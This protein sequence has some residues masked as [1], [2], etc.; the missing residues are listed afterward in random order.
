M[1]YETYPILIARA[2]HATPTV[3]TTIAELDTVALPE[4]SVTETDAS[5][6]NHT[7][8]NWV[9]STLVRRKA[10]MFTMNFLPADS[11]QDHLTGLQAALFA[12]TFDG[13]RF[14]HAASGLLWVASGNVTIVTPKTPFEGKLQADVTL[15]F[16]GPMAINGVT[17][18]T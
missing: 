18:G 2:L 10:T 6:Q 1:A 12:Q 11:T 16:S 4:F 13:Y 8:D 9:T 15:R 3:W 14:S 7:I 5:T 17:I